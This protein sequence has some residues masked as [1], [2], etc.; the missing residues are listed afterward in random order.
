MQ[1]GNTQNIYVAGHK[2]MVGSAVCRLL[3]KIQG[4]SILSTDRNDVDLRNQLH[5]NGYIK[6]IKPDV[7]IIAAAKVGG[8]L[9]NDS[10]P[11][12]FLYD[13]LM[14]ESNLIHAAHINNVREVYY[15]GSSCI[16]PKFAQQP[17]TE[18]QLLTGQLE[19][20]NQWYAIAKIAGIKLCEAL[21][22][23]Y[24]RNYVSIMPTNLYGPNDN[25]DLVTS[26]VLPAMIRKFHIA[27]TEGKPVELWGSGNPLREFLHVDDLA[28]AIIFAMNR[29]IEGGFYNVG[30]GED[31]SIKELAEMIAEIIG[32]K[33]KIVWDR[34]KP[35]GT[36]RKLMDSSKFRSLGW[37]PK[38]DLKTGIKQT[39]QWYLKNIVT[40]SP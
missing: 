37:K 36:P 25:F 14:I 17:I 10:Y 23:Q 5:V 9:A 11:Y 30:Y 34:E 24:D 18:D 4:Y 19:P 6:N 7:I 31:I 21:N 38:I 35:D 26:H 29:K 1:T 32:Y 13:N 3:S 12:E 8:I 39:Y 28:S 2:G 20:T 40:V 16:Y 15:L 33:G 22:K 27:I